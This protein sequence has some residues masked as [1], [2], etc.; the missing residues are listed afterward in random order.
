MKSGVL[1]LSRRR[2]LLGLLTVPIGAVPAAK[3]LP[4]ALRVVAVDSI[5]IAVVISLDITPVA[6]CRAADYR[7]GH[8]D[9]TLSAAT[10]DIGLESQPNLELLV[11]LQPDFIVANW[12]INGVGSLSRVAPIL[13]L[14]LYSGQ[15]DAY[16]A[17]QQA[18]RSLAGRLNRQPHAEAAIAEADAVITTCRQR[19]AS[20]SPL[21]PLYLVD[22]SFGS[23]MVGV[24]GSHSMLDAVVMRLGLRN[25]WHEPDQ[26]WGFSEVEVARLADD[27]TALIVCLRQYDSDDLVVERRLFRTA[28]WRSLP[29]VQWGRVVT[30][31]PTDFFGGLQ[32]ASR[33]AKLLTNALLSYTK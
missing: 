29:A 15:P 5:A 18:L 23:G 32:T 10:T 25:A 24:Y 14:K 28:L 3:A 13:P 12:T 9:I 19:L 2:T 22:L 16:T 21:P 20:L 4:A 6:T 33:F 7:S 1:P 31:P 11:K 30:V 8:A 27:Q 17:L 26:F